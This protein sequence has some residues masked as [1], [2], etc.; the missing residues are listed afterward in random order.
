MQWKR[1]PLHSGGCLAGCN[2]SQAFCSSGRALLAETRR[3]AK[4]LPAHRIR[5]Q[6]SVDEQKMCDRYCY[7]ADAY[8]RHIGMNRG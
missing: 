3:L 8:C 5:A 4:R 7:V 1:K 6:I 2:G